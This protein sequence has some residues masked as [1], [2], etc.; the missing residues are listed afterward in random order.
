MKPWEYSLVENGFATLGASEV[1]NML[2]IAEYLGQ[3]VPATPGSRLD[4]LLTLE[5]H[6]G[7]GD[8][9]HRF[10][11]G[12][13][14]WHTD[15]AYYPAPPRFVL[16]RLHEATGRVRPTLLWNLARAIRPRERQIL[17]DGRW[18]VRSP[19]A[20]FF[21]SVL[22]AVELSSA[23]RVR[24]DPVCM[25]PYLTQ[26]RTAATQ[27]ERLL[28][29]AESV[30][31]DW[32]EHRGLVI[33]NWRVLHCRPPPTIGE[34]RRVLKRVLVCTSSAKAGQTENRD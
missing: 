23:L 31:I 17:L 25:T 10:G 20:R 29:D 24:Y 13:F 5:P 16:L 7:P 12:P 26:G 6:G 19:G 15:A 33:D 4:D 14:P 8:W 34:G 30:S 22:Q 28:A 32:R 9:S 27:L 11:S 18:R 3:P 2:S 21:S 1:S